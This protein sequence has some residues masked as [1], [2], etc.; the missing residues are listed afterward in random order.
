MAQGRHSRAGKPYRDKFWIAVYV[1]DEERGER[2]ENIFGTPLEFACW[3]WNLKT[4]N[5][6]KGSP[7]YEK[8]QYCFRILNQAWHYVTGNPIPWKRNGF[9]KNGIGYTIYMIAID[10]KDFDEYL[11]LDC[12][13]IFDNL[14]PEGSYKL[15]LNRK[16]EKTE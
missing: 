15:R 16:E 14:Y 10:D 13:R 6:H 4:I 11:S 7:S 12:D 3:F 5:P 9:R 2:L 8:L 1:Q